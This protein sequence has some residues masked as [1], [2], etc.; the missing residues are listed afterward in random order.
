MNGKPRTLLTWLG[1]SERPVAT[2][3]SGRDLFASLYSISGSGLA[4][5][6]TTGR[7]AMERTISGVTTLGPESPRNAS[8]PRIASARV[9]Q[10]SSVANSAL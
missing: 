4:M 5:A 9:R 8:A 1:Q 2:I 7:S 3:A 10:R 6:R